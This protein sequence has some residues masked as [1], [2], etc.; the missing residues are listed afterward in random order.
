MQNIVDYILNVKGNLDQQLGSAANH[1]KTLETNLV[2]VKSMAS[3]IAGA[4]GVGFAVFQ[5]IDFVKKGVE[6][7]KELE[8]V[9]A[10]VE[11]NLKSTGGVAGVSMKNIEEYSKG[12]S[13]KIHASRVDIMDMASQML[14]FPS[15]SKDVFQSSMGLIADIAKQTGHGL[16]ETAIMYGKALNDPSAGL[17]KMMRYGVVFTEQEKKR[18]QALQASGDLIGAQKS[19]MDA[20]AGSGYAGV[21]EA[22]FNADPIARFNK[23]MG[24]AQV[25][26]GEIAVEALKKIMPLLESFASIIKSTAVFLKEHSTAILMVV[27]ILGSAILA[28]KTYTAVTAA[29]AII[30]TGLTSGTWLL[31]AAWTALDV[32]MSLN[33]IGLIIA[34][35]SALVAIVVVCWNKFEGFREIVLGVWEVIKW[36]GSE[37][38]KV[39]EGLYNAWMGLHTFDLNQIKQGFAQL[40]DVWENGGRRAGE[41]WAKGQAEGA[42]SMADSHKY[43]TDKAIAEKIASLS[44]AGKITSKAQAYAIANLM[45]KINSDL[46]SKLITEEQKAEILS[47]LP[48]KGKKGANLNI[49]AQT[50]DA[51]KPKTKAEGRKNINITVTYN[52]PLIQD[53]TISSTNITDGLESLKNKVSEILVGATHDTL[54]VADH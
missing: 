50:S 11:A 9:T 5:G 23:M 10:K 51:D 22:M 40:S 43:E 34:G 47:L 4:L 45:N 12:L 54:L 3:T 36:F 26:I 33:P 30:Q 28:Y 21:A 2:G 25:A 39:I 27:S 32:V 35:I 18:I 46:K 15:I 8:E 53:F 24:G 31:T 14:T 52:A 29:Y 37:V 6:K 41:A 13:G 20:I 17:Q 42:K 44:E 48:Q 7:F 1:A 19:M 16:S 38:I 49:N